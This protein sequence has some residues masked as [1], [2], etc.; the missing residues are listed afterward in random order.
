[1][2]TLR[3]DEPVWQAFCMHGITH[4]PVAFRAASKE[5]LAACP[6]LEF[7]MQ[8]WFQSVCDTH[9]GQLLSGASQ[10]IASKQAKRIAMLKAVERGSVPLMTWLFQTHGPFELNY[11]H[12][13][14][15]LIHENAEQ[16]TTCLFDQEPRASES[17]PQLGRAFHLLIQIGYQTTWSF[18]FVLDQH[19]HVLE[20]DFGDYE[21]TGRKPRH[22]IFFRGVIQKALL[23]TDRRALQWVR[24]KAREF[25]FPEVMA[26]VCIVHDCLEE[27]FGNLAENKAK[28][29]R[30]M[31]FLNSC[32]FELDVSFVR[33]RKQAS[34][35]RKRRVKMLPQHALP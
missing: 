5:C 21:A 12:V 15:A 32:G 14:N 30:A 16:L 4:A 20:P 19:R 29:G 31:R 24:P 25:V 17:L 1:M 26:N 13:I 7:Y 2:G 33:K 18:D 9:D 6:P 10:P 3:D 23:H 8:R 35:E 27:V 34:V 22:R 11:S 28:F